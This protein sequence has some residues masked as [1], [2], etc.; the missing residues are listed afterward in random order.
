[1]PG[2]CKY[3]AEGADFGKGLR[4]T[5]FEQRIMGFW[6][7]SLKYIRTSLTVSFLLWKLF[8]LSIALLAPGPGYDTSS[9]LLFRR[10]SESGYLTSDS[11]KAP[12]LSKLVRWDAIYFTQVAHRGYEFEQEWAFGWGFTKLI[13]F[14]TTGIPTVVYRKNMDKD[15]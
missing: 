11:P 5:K 13:A 9:S 4:S 12:R 10:S 3:V 14:V 7:L 6:E 2:W 1:M 15:V 8:L